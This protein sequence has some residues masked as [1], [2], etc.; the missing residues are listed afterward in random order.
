M[1]NFEKYKDEIIEITDDSNL[2][3]QLYDLKKMM[4]YQK[5]RDDEFLHDF[6][7][8]LAKEAK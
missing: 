8:W 4:G 1:T 3:A 5:Q 7:N 2:Y 6:F